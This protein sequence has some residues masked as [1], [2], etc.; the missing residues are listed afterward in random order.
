MDLKNLSEEESISRSTQLIIE[1]TD[2]YIE[3]MN[4][5]WIKKIPL[6]RAVIYFL[7]FVFIFVLI[8]TL[9]F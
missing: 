2:L 5:N 8:L 9:L 1:M 4:S 6:Q 7:T 3:D